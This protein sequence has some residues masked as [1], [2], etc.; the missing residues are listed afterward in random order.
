[1]DGTWAIQGTLVNYSGGYLGDTGDSGQLQ[2]RVLGRYRGHWS[3]TVEGT[4]AI[5]GT[6]V[7]YSGGYLGD[8][9]DIG[10]L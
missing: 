10:Q 9:G 3:I 5:Q 6:L 2:W 7:N 1:M 4:W 8:T